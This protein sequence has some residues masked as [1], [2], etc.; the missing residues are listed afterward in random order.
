MTDVFQPYERFE[1]ADLETLTR[2]LELGGSHTR[3]QA[4]IT[5]A[6]RCREDETLIANVVEAIQDPRNHRD[7][8]FAYSVADL[9]MGALVAVGTEP[10]LQ[11][12]RRL[13]ATSSDL[14]KDRFADLLRSGG[15]TLDPS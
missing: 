5:L 1:G 12:V 3:V 6:L 8:I 14:D 11:A 7:R 9:G 15:M 4:L 13:L 10:A 2:A